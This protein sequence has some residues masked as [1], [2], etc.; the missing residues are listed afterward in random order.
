M[1][2]PKWFVAKEP[3]IHKPPRNH[4]EHYG[5]FSWEQYRKVSKEKVCDEKFFDRGFNKIACY[6]Q[7]RISGLVLLFYFFF[8]FTFF[9]LFLL[10]ILLIYQ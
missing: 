2:L 8:W 7:L 3:F 6:F 9:C 5:W 4:N 10:C 1:D